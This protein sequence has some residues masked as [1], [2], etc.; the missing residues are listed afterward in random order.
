[1]SAEAARVTHAN[2]ID[3]HMPVEAGTNRR[4]SW[5]AFREAGM[6]WAINRVLHMFGWAIVVEVDDDSG[7]TVGA[8]PVRTEWRGFPRDREDLGYQRTA[9]WMEKA[10]VAIREET[11]RE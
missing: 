1:M 9:E 4:H 2:D 11:G 10:A 6:L 3:A 8:Y 7:E 5:G